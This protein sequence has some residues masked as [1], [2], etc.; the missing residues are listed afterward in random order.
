MA[1]MI[2]SV[3]S[4]EVRSAA[5]RRIFEW[6]QNDPQTE[7]WIV[8]HSLG[9]ANH[10]TVL[11]GELDFFVIAPGLGVFALEV[12]GGRVKREEGVWY[13]INRYDQ[14][15]SKRRGP[16]EQANEGM[17]SIKQAIEKKCGSK[18]NLSKLL[19]GSGVMFPD[20]TFDAI[21]MDGEQW[22][23]FDEN[24]LGNISG[25][26]KRLAKNTRRKWEEKYGP[27]SPDMLPDKKAARE[28]ANMLRGDFDKAV[29][30]ST[31]INNAETSLISL[32]EEQLRCLDQLEDNA[33]CL[34]HG[35]AGTGKTLLA[36]EEAKKSVARGEKV[37]L[38]CFN[39]MLGNWLK[40]YFNLMDV[41]LRPTYVGTFHAFMNQCICQDAS[42]GLIARCGENSS[43]F[44]ED[45][46]IMAIEAIDKYPQSFD[47]IIIDEAQDLI[48]NDYLDV[49]DMVLKGGIVRGKWSMFGDFSMQAIYCDGCSSQTMRDQIE[50]RTSFVNFH[51]RINCRN[52]K[53]IGEEI[54]CITGFDSQ[55]YIWTK[56]QGPPVNY[57]SYKDE[58]EQKEKLSDLLIK[59]QTE[60]IKDSQITILSPCRREGSV[61]S[62]LETFNIA[63]YRPENHNKISFSTI[64]S[65][66]GLENTVIILTDIETF[67]H[68]K[69]MY[70]GL[71]RARTAL[72]IFTSKKAAKEREK[73][74]MRLLQ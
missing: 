8:L 3:I 13:F 65:Y 68:T 28:L 63:E 30:I 49:M 52:T 43:F 21:D 40:Y 66:K 53:P 41:D 1:R 10:K 22:Q 37:A 11:Y 4:P 32:T 38:F 17:F 9:I 6:F 62:S 74:L 64:H 48:N 26:I 59:L 44:R 19:Y 5:E 2:P 54:K 55:K 14:I 42:P 29:S 56:V 47:K 72:F 60:G 36:I 73:M 18:H 20:I 35:P 34:I 7:D 33:R 50:E 57:Y 15:S 58:D 69:L 39:S 67:E 16:F 31:Q 61:V 51:L 70:V 46:P 24:D 25:Y 23:V 45:M 27:I 71:S 12:K